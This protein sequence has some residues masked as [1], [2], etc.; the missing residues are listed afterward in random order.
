MQGKYSLWAATAV[1]I[2]N[3]IGTGV[4]TSLG[5]QLLSTSDFATI[6][7]LWVLGG[8][9]ALS[10][11]FAYSELGAAMPQ[12][13]GEYNFLSQIYHPS[14]GFLS[15]WVSATIGF[16]APIALCAVTLGKYFS[17]VVP[18]VN[19]TYLGLGV[20]IGA[21]IIHSLKHSIGGSFQTVFTVLKVLLIGV[22]IVFGFAYGGVPH[23]SFM[24]SSE[25][26]SNMFSG[27][28]AVSL[29]YVSFAYSGWNASSY[30]AGEVAEPKRNIPLS[31]L[32]G[33]GI[34]AILYVLLNAVFLHTAPINELVVDTATFAPREVA[35][36]SA[37]HVFG[38]NVGK[39]F[40]VLISIFLVSTISSMIIAGPRIIFAIAH[41]FKIFN[42]FKKTNKH[43]VPV[44]AIWF[45]SL[46]ACIILITSNF[47]RI[48]T[49][50]TFALTLFSTLTVL[51]VIVYRYRNPTAD[52]PYKTFGYPFSCLFFVSS[53]I[54]FLGFIIKDK[55]IESL[56]GLGIVGA[57]VLVYAYSS[58]Q[59]KSF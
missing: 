40:S 17:T 50:T 30:I 38:S 5:Y 6:I 37:S 13:G 19:A 51:G 41:N 46:I 59:K 4:F 28:F 1:V 56:I 34:V 12:S 14:V 11:A 23:T 49:Y 7:L 16:S 52:R 25:T 18:G 20:I 10:G 24:P 47:D 29:V 57:G 42:V 22:F 45:Q 8:A 9:I 43:G 3:M 58:F 21:T 33:T 55:P 36:V 44:V 2:A 31:I 39:G 27:S 53:N 48:I 54:W 26:W 15:G 35:F 32:A